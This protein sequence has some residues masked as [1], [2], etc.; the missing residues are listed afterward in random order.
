MQADPVAGGE[1]IMSLPVDNHSVGCVVSGNKTYWG[2]L[3][4]FVLGYH[5]TPLVPPYLI[6]SH[7]RNINTE[8]MPVLL[9]KYVLSKSR[10]LMIVQIR[11]KY[12]SSARQMPILYAQ[13]KHGRS[14]VLLTC[15]TSS[16]C[17]YIVAFHGRC[18]MYTCRF[19][20]KHSDNVAYANTCK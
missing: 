20:K 5:V 2:C 7:R 12:V 1:W 9:I 19:G 6:L 4:I 10:V 18:C 17:A 15:H 16:A 14:Q 8:L 13:V 3:K 11:W